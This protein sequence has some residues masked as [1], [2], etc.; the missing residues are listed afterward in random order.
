MIELANKLDK[1]QPFHVMD[2]LAKAKQMQQDGR[3]IIHLEV[4]KERRVGKECSSR[5]WPNQKK[6]NVPGQKRT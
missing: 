6:K 2:L 3:D 4:G 1:I 5:W